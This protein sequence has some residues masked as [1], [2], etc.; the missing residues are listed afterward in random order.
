MH[1][2]AQY[3][4]FEESSKFS[5]VSSGRYCVQMRYLDMFTRPF[6]SKFASSLNITRNRKKIVIISCIRHQICKV[7]CFLLICI[8]ARLL[9]RRFK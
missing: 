6:I 7:S 8:F 4:N 5:S 2:A 9:D 3:I 1:Y